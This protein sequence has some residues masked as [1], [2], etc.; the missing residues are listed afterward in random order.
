MTV[1]VTEIVTEITTE[2]NIVIEIMTEI[3]TETPEIDE[4]DL[5]LDLGPE[6]IGITD[7][8]SLTSTRITREMVVTDVSSAR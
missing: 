3:M 5:D 4:I 8:T 1:V 7:N 6:T 2:T